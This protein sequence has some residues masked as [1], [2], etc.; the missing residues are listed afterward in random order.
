MIDTSA[1]LWG[2]QR[3]RSLILLCC[4]LAFLAL[5]AVSGAILEPQALLCDLAQKNLSPSWQHPFGTDALGRD[6][7]LRTLSGLSRSIRVGLV[8]A[9]AS[10]I[11][12]LLLG[13]L[14][15]LGRPWISG[16]LSFLTDLAL[17]IPHILLLLLISYA[18]GK[19]FWGVA[20][21][22]TL[23]HWPGLSRV[24]RAET[25]QVKDSGYV[26]AARRLGCSQLRIFR[27]HLLP[28]LLPQLLAGLILLFPHAILHEASVTFLGF[29]LPPD[30]PAIGSILAE[31]MQY[32]SLGYWWLAL[33]PG[34]L[35]LVTV[36]LFDL[37][38]EAARRLLD[39]A[40]AHL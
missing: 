21:G 30:Q 16:S 35:L 38:G 11:L 17:G 1:R 6:M 40:S 23:S 12:A 20:L 19:G 27:D 25:L 2:E 39:P 5:I 13:V 18:C 31:S 29:G 22:V 37:L 36:L 33:F 32:L 8:T 10:A 7:L 14:A 9:A 4:A 15:A 26:Q 24:L 34:L 28:H 3:R